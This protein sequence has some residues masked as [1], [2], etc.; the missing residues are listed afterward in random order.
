[1]FVVAIVGKR[2]GETFETLYEACR[3]AKGI[4]GAYVVETRTRAKTRHVAYYNCT[5]GTMIP[6][7]EATPKERE[8]IFCF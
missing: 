3:A 8:E 2:A 1:M 6:M 7:F 4:A 5:V